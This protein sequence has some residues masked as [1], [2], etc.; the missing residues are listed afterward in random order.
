MSVDEKGV[1][2]FESL[3]DDFVKN[4]KDASFT[5]FLDEN[6]VE[7]YVADGYVIT[8]DDNYDAFCFDIEFGEL[9]ALSDCFWILGIKYYDEKTNKFSYDQV[10][11][12]KIFYDDHVLHET[13]KF[14]IFK[15]Y[16]VYSK[17]LND[18]FLLVDEKGNAAIITGDDLQKILEEYFVA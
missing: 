9:F 16:G 1:K 11:A 18:Q 6:K 4:Y 5:K 8:D 17:R 13:D 12:K 2:Y 3:M 10:N 7:Y 14:R 15:I